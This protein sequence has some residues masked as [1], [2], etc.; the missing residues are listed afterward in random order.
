MATQTEIANRALGY[1]GDETI[2]AFSDANKR[3]R[4]VTL[5]YDG[6]RRRALRLHPWN[7]VSSRASLAKDATD[8]IWGFDSRFKLP[9]DFERLIDIEN[10]GGGLSIEGNAQ[11][12]RYEIEDGFIHT[13]LSAPLNIKYVRNESDTSK[14]DSLLTTVVAYSLAL[15]LVEGLT[16][17]NTKKAALETSMRF[18][19]KEAQRVS[20]RERAPQRFRDTT[21]I[22][23]RLRGA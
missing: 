20:G 2:T 8:P 19:L 23:A 6:A 5:Y 3:A 18:W 14:F 11:G 1:V 10:T 22:N 16:Q 13:D 4:L 7:K 15:D 17:S 21:W 9:S 12:S